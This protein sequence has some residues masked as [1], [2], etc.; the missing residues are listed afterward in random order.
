MSSEAGKA[1]KEL[2]LSIKSFSYPSTTV[3]YLL[4][5]KKAVEE[6]NITL[7]TS[8]VGE[9]DVFELIPLIT[10]TSILID[11]V[12]CVETICV[13]VEELSEQAHFKK[14]SDESEKPKL[15]YD[16]VVAPVYDDRQDRGFVTIVIHKITS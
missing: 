15:H 4:T 9:W 13:A 7:Q 11:I 2:A 5:C 14:S 6:V 16:G 3:I 12:K 8:M 10:I 1:L